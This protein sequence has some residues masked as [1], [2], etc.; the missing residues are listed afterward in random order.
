MPVIL[1]REAE[2]VW[3]D[4]SIQEPARLLPL[5]SPYPA[6]D[7][8][9][10]PVSRRMN[11]PTYVGLTVSSRYGNQSATA[12][13]SRVAGHQRSPWRQQRVCYHRSTA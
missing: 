1:A 12:D 5:L 7:M 9:A 8:E 3:L 2:T 10:Y 13:A 6:E 4:P 11:S